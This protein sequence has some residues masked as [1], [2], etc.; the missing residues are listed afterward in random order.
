MADTQAQTPDLG[1]GPRPQPRPRPCERKNR[2]LSASCVPTMTACA[3]CDRRLLRQLRRSRTRRPSSDRPASMLNTGYSWSWS[4]K[5]A[6]MDSPK[7]H[8]GAPEPSHASCP[9]QQPVRA[10]RDRA[11]VLT[12]TDCRAGRGCRAAYRSC[13]PLWSCGAVE[14]RSL[15]CS[16]TARATAARRR[17][18]RGWRQFRRRQRAWRQRQR[19]RRRQ[20]WWVGRQRR[21]RRQLESG[22]RRR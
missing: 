6:F 1:H 22:A 5:K 3:A 4:E 7:A 20:R 15:R 9:C 18:L 14:W 12:P 11:A 8:S 17:R 13:S 19:R 2:V 10:A 21:R 16:S